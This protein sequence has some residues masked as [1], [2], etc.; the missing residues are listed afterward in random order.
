M[1]RHTQYKDLPMKFSNLSK[2]TSAGAI[3]FLA[4]FAGASYAQTAPNVTTYAN[5][6]TAPAGTVEIDGKLWVSDHVQGF[7]RLD[8][9]ASGG[10][11][12][13]NA[14]TC[15]T[16]AISAGQPSFDGTFVY[17]PDNSSKSQGVWRLRYSAT[18]G[19]FVTA[20][21][22]ANRPVL[23]ARN[24]N[25]RPTATTL[26]NGSLFI[27][28]LRNGNI[29]RVNNP[30]GT[31]PGTAT[32]V[33]RTS[34]GR[35]AAS[36]TS[37]GANLYIAEGAGVSSIPSDPNELTACGRPCIASLLPSNF[38]VGPT[39]IASNGESL[40]VADVTNEVIKYTPG[41]DPDFPDGTEEIYVA[42][43]KFRFIS[44][45]GIKSGST[46]LYVGDDPTDGNGIAQGHIYTVTP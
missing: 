8:V 11:A 40:Y 15:V 22:S 1:T 20:T 23:V 39:A 5:G 29:L 18:T 43:G 21:N 36:L 13:I 31:T 7:C 35:G 42:G 4:T 24:G 32:T 45:L 3:A 27:G 46:T 10:A 19:R 6:I 34:D 2:T 25:A 33:G 12:A 41:N 30:G 16:T 14:A 9:P 28:S 38:I 44:G 17:L 26:V 37:L